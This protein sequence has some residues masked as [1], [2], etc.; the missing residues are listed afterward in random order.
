[1][2]RCDPR[3]GALFQ[4]CAGLRAQYIDIGTHNHVLAVLVAAVSRLS[5]GPEAIKAALGD[6][7][8]AEGVLA[9][10]GDDDPTL[11][12]T[13]EFLDAWRVGKD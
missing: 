7:E 11:L 13:S 5:G 3:P 1:M 4:T 12:M 8:V 6:V 10:F 9:S 2:P